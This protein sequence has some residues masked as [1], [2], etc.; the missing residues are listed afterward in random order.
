[1]NWTE[2]LPTIGTFL[3]G[4]AGGIAAAAVEWLA[5]K[6]GVSD[7]TISAVTDQLN[8]TPA[9]QLLQMKQLDNEFKEF[10]MSNGIKV[11]LAQIGV[12][13]EEAKSVNWFVAGWRPFVGWVCGT[14]LL[15]V[16]FIEPIMRFIAKMNGYT[17]EFPV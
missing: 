4:P 12:N 5:G 14:G 6:L 16:S 7:K 3:G 15:Y 17:G 1:M 2:I 10:C 9:D 8:K 11:E 13:T